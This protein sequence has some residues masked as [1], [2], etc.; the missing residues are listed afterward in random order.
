MRKSIKSKSSISD[1]SIYP[2][3]EEVMIKLYGDRWK[4]LGLSL[5]DILGVQMK[6]GKG[7]PSSEKKT[8]EFKG[9]AM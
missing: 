2:P 1:S 8:E 3:K 6:K 4:A 7:S 5:E 9:G